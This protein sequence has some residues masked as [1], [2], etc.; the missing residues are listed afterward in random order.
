LHAGSVYILIVVANELQLETR[1]YSGHTLFISHVYIFRQERCSIISIHLVLSEIFYDILAV[2]SSVMV[3][4]VKDW[5]HVF[6]LLMKS[7]QNSS[8]E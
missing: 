4:S 3:L 6:P 7:V 5:L 8:N 1:E 2:P